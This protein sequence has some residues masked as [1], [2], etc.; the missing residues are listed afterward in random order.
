VSGER[1]TDTRVAPKPFRLDDWS[2]VPGGKSIR[3]PFLSTSLHGIT[4][5]DLETVAAV[6]LGIP[7]TRLLHDAKPDWWEWRARWTFDGATIDLAMTVLDPPDGRAWGGVGLSGSATPSA[8]VVLYNRLHQALPCAWLHNSA[9]ELHTASSFSDL[10]SL[11]TPAQQ[12]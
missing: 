8:V 10:A 11:A 2:I 9:C 5:Y 6:I 7:G 1:P 3:P 4:N 12:Q